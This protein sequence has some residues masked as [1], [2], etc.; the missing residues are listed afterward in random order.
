MSEGVF[1]RRNFW[2]ADECA[3]LRLAMDSGTQ[4][5]A[6]VFE[7]DFVVRR[8]VRDALDVEPESNVVAFVEKSLDT[9]MPQVSRHFG[10]RLHNSEGAGFL[11]YDAGGHYGAHHDVLDAEEAHFPRLI[12]VVVFLSAVQGGALRLHP[13]DGGAPIDIP[14]ETGTLVAFRS[15]VL[16]EVLPVVSGI[17]D[18]VVDWY[19]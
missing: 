15:D 17:R 16:H 19:Y 12:S 9:V 2:S 13:A 6:E 1:I 5:P 8:D 14:P 3:R 11:R 10:V 18:V 7:G 4:S